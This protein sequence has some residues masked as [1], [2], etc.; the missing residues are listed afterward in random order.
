M[1]QTVALAPVLAGLV[2]SEGVQ[3]V[4]VV[5][6]LVAVDVHDRGELAGQ[7]GGGRRRRRQLMLAMMILGC[8]TVKLLVV[9]TVH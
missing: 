1:T 8:R 7:P 6:D 5:G 3:Q 9:L 4:P 2:V